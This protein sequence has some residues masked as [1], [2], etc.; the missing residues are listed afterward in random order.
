MGDRERGEVGV[1][2]CGALVA[3]CFGRYLR[4]RKWCAPG[5]MANN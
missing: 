2:A 5:A 4:F 1:H 3:R